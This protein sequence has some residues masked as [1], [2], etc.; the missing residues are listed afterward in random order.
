MKKYIHEQ[1]EYIIMQAHA[2]THNDTKLLI[3]YLVHMK[4]KLIYNLPQRIILI[5]IITTS[6]KIRFAAISF[7]R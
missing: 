3:H 1:E 6:T 4:N 7:F 2:H 5:E